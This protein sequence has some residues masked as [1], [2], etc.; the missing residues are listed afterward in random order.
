[1]KNLVDKIN[2]YEGGEMSDQEIIEFFQELVL[3][4][5]LHG[6]QGHYGRTASYLVEHGHIKTKK[7]YEMQLVKE[8]E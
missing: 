8:G 3:K 7:E 6:L 4:D 2:S 1:M 5:K